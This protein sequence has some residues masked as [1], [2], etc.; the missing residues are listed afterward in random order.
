MGRWVKF[1]AWLSRRPLPTRTWTVLL[2]HRQGCHL[3]D[4]AWNLLTQLRQK[5]GFTL[6]RIDID[7]HPDLV[8]EHGEHVPV[9]V[10]NGRVRFRGIVNPVLLRRLF[11]ARRDSNPR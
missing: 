10:V 5:Y 8:R 7:P 4:D 2:Y 1:W 3:C 6:E 11:A 9:I